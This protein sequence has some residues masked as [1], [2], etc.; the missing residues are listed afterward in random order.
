MSPGIVPCRM[1][2]WICC[3]RPVEGGG[4]AGL[5]LRRGRQNPS[6]QEVLIHKAAV[7]QGRDVETRG[8]G[9]AG[10]RQ[11]GKR[12]SLAT[13]ALDG[14]LGAIQPEDQ[15]PGLRGCHR[16]FRSSPLSASQWK[17][18]VASGRSAGLS[19][20]YAGPCEGSRRP[21]RASRI[22]GPALKTRSSQGEVGLSP[23]RFAVHPSPQSWPRFSGAVPS[24]GV[25]FDSAGLKRMP[26]T[27]DSRYGSSI[28][29]EHV[30]SAKASSARPSLETLT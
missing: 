2:D 22:P 23:A 15:G 17:L 26:R 20:D 9:Q 5:R 14:R 29:F 19:V 1:S 8:H 28:L 6:P 4:V 27:T 7:G 16:W 13:D 11:S 24:T 25:P 21:T 10:S 30:A 12:C 3:R 18:E